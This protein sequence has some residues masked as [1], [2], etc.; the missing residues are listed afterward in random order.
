[1]LDRSSRKCAWRKILVN[2]PVLQLNDAMRFN[3]AI[4]IVTIAL[5]GCEKIPTGARI[6]MVRGKVT[7][8]TS[9]KT[10]DAKIDRVIGSEDIITTEKDSAVDL[11]IAGGG[12]F[13]V[14]ENSKVTIK[15]LGKQSEMNLDKGAMLLGLRKLAPKEDFTVR[16]PTALAGVRGTSF[17]I[18]AE[19]NTIAVLTGSVEVKKGESTVQVDQLKEIKTTGDKPQPT[20]LSRESV[21]ELSSISTIE[22]IQNVEGFDEI[23]KNLSLVTLEMDKE[24]INSTQTISPREH[25]ETK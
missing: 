9:G 25:Q 16:T 4:F 22:G 7:V 19:R 20:R 24:S 1:M 23:Q 3:V 14:S 15:T 2:L 5:I 10:E 6:T 21:S 18:S 12:A 11:Q 8:Q 13:R 17:S